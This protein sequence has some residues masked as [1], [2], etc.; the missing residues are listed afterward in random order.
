MV[1]SGPPLLNPVWYSVGTRAIAHWPCSLDCRK[2][3][4]LGM[5]FLDL[6]RSLGFTE[7]VE[8][9]M[10]LL[11]W[12]VEWSALHGIAEIRTPVVKIAG[13]NDPTTER[14]VVRWME[15]AFPPTERAGLAFPYSQSSP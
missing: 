6:G 3:E 5:Q 15:R 13:R 9:L 4:Q 14:Y 12:P 2:S 1:A 10:E 8:C 11:D 7:E